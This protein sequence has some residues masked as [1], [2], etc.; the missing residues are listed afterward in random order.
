MAGYHQ[1]WAA[2]PAAPDSHYHSH[3]SSDEVRTIFVFG[4]P[5]DVKERELQNL[6]RWWPGYEASQINF[7]GDQALGFALFSTPQFAMQ[8]RDALQNLVFDAENNSILRA[9]MAKK[10]LY[11]KRGVTVVA[12]DTNSF[13]HSKRMRT[14]GDYNPA[15]YPAPGTFVPQPAPV[16]GPQGYMAPPSAQYDLYGG[17]PQVQPVP[18]PV[19]PAGYAPVQ[20]MKDNPPCNT[21]FI[22]NLGENTSEAELRGL[23]SVQPGFKQMK[24]LH[25]GRSTVCFIEFEDI[26]SAVVVHNNLQGAV[27]TSSDR[28]GM[29][30]QYSKN[31][32]GRKKDGSGP[33]HAA[34]AAPGMPVPFFNGVPTTASQ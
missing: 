16:W 15:A 20:N 28:G 21:L 17:Y 8:A 12:P 2:P 34:G 18:M 19:A 13:D 1:Q 24:V 31:P 5:S 32:Y 30:I 4:F 9:E 29:R 33:P 23:F 10:N 26:N 7:K 14:G 11:V 6:L 3:N 27:I 25:Q 22:G